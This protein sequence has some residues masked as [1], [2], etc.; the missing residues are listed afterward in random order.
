M[1]LQV[2]LPS[3]THTVIWNQNDSLHSKAH[4]IALSVS[5]LVAM[6]NARTVMKSDSCSLSYMCVKYS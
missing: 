4:Q 6:L 5:L 1:C 3:L 2:A